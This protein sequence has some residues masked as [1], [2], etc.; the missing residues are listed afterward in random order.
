MKL[1]WNNENIEEATSLRLTQ[2]VT[3][4]MSASSKVL[5]D[6]HIF[7]NPPTECPHFTKLEGSS[8]PQSKALLVLLDPENES[9]VNL[10]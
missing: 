3:K 8:P 10:R 4:A 7:L 5:P 2:S 6:K 9:N 1:L